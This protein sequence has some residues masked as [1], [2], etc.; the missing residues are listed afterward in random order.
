MLVDS[1]ETSKKQVT[2]RLYD[3]L[4]LGAKLESHFDYRIMLESHETSRIEKNQ[5]YALMT[6]P[7]GIKSEIESEAHKATFFR[8]VLNRENVAAI[9]DVWVQR[10]LAAQVLASEEH[11]EILDITLHNIERLERLQEFHWITLWIIS[12]F[13]TITPQ[14]V[15]QNQESLIP[16][17][18]T[19]TAQEAIKNQVADRQ[20]TEEETAYF[21][22]PSS[23]PKLLRRRNH[24]QKTSG[25]VELD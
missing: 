17:L 4:E 14:A 15:I 3:I 16:F 18:I 13:I 9:G 8:A 23:S 5:Q 19:R 6:N 11:I 1:E 12:F 22:T 21:L 25:D 2:S 10:M 24:V 7:L 20:K